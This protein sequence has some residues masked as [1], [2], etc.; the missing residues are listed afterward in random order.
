MSWLDAA[1]TV[2]RD[3]TGLVFGQARR[4][5]FERAVM[6]GMRRARVRAPSD[7]FA[8]VAARAELMDDLVADI[9][10]GETY[11]FREPRQLAVLRTQILPDLLAQR[12]AGHRLRIWSAGCATGEEAYTLAILAREVG[13]DP[14]PYIIATDISRVS[15]KRA[16]LARYGRWSLRGT[17]P[18]VVPRYF[19]ADGPTFRL[20]ASLRASV[21]FGYL[22]LAADAYPSLAT[23]VWGMDVVLCRN[24]LMYFDRETVMNVSRRLIDALAV[25]G[26]LVLGPSDPVLEAPAHCDIVVTEAGLMYHRS[27]ER[28]ASI[29]AIPSQS[30]RASPIPPVQDAWPAPHT[31][32]TASTSRKDLRTPSVAVCAQSIAEVRELANRGALEEAGRACAAA[33]DVHRQSAELH[34]L[35]AV[36]L[37][38]AGHCAE[39]AR[40]ARAALY[41][42]R[43]LIVAQIAL[44]TALVRIGNHDEARRAFRNAERLLSK[45][46]PD[47]PVPAANHEPAA[48]LAEMVRTRLA[49]LSTVA[50]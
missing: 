27:A 22:N 8:Q 28:K 50:A 34:Y 19:D 13:L 3:R 37:A 5:D 32:A 33:L 11:F 21:E 20:D 35:H 30:L 6:A 26:W 41:L 36:L 2:V 38:E 25:G 48:R 17:P 18:D 7:Y 9:T 31:P 45:L 10:V 4:A 42:D 40:A 29:T 15:L 23:G 14:Q 16:G 39:S 44:G 43:E 1:A 49:L 24:V 12:P 46:S 47:A